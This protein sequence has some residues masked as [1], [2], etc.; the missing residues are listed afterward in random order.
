MRKLFLGIISLLGIL[1]FPVLSCDATTDQSYVV[2]GEGNQQVIPLAYSVTEVKVSFPSTPDILSEP[3]DICTDIHDNLYILDSGNGR[4]LQLNAAGEFVREIKPV[5]QYALSAPQGIYV[6]GAGKIYIADTGNKRILVL[7]SLGN[8]THELTQPDSPMYDAEYPFEPLKVGVNALGQIYAINN[9]DYHGF[10]ILDLDNEFKGYFAATR[11]KKNAWRELIQRF[12]SKSQKEQMGKTIPAQHTNFFISEDGSIYVTTA[13]VENEQLKRMSTVGINF[14]PYSGEFGDDTID[15][16]MTLQGKKENKTNFVDVS[17]DNSG[18]ISILDNATGRIYQ[19]DSS[20]VMLLVFGGTGNWSG[21]MMNAVA[22]TQDSKGCIYVL[23]SA[24]ASVQKFKPTDFTNTIHTALDLHNNGEYTEAKALW[25]D[26]LAVAPQYPPANIGLG[27]AETKQG[28]YVSAMGKY[29]KAGDKYGYSDAF[30]RYMKQQV[31][32]KFLWIVLL[33]VGIL[34][35][36]ISTVSLFKQYSDKIRKNESDHHAGKHVAVVIMFAPWEAFRL[37]QYDRNRFYK[38]AP[39][40]ILTVSVIVSILRFFLL[41]Y[42]FIETKVE[43]INVVQQMC[44]FLI[45]FTLWVFGLYYVTCVFSGEVKLR[46]VYSATCYALLPF[47]IFSIPLALSTN[48]MGVKSVGTVNTLH[49]LIWIWVVVL[50]FL[51]IRTMN[52]YSTGKTINVMICSIFAMLLLA[53]VMT[54]VYLLGV[55]LMNFVVEVIDECKLVF[56]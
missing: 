33:T 32:K 9:L 14:Y 29:K 43:D 56:M 26:V 2:D 37:I 54:L 4:V 1:F 21:R 41:H 17:V 20:G 35:S 39:T 53:V 7:D 13:N 8:V 25:K 51:G 6:D 38:F 5:N 22:M 52:H 12:A 24:S 50:I 45:P 28:E 44:T 27:K 47:A 46:E 34:V 42:P 48:L 30:S 15:Y 3:K 10:C 36:I 23:D 49:V 11:L 55:K 40:L 18:I 19:Y 31:Q 16:L